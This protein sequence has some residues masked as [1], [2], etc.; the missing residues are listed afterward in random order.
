MRVIV[1]GYGSRPFGE[2]KP[3]FTRLAEAGAEIVVND[4][5]PVGRGRPVGPDQRQID[6]RQEYQ[7]IGS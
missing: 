1:D 7:E 5:F 6:W 2:A 3:M 4:I